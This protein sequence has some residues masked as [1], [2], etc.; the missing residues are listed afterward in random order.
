M[1]YWYPWNCDFVKSV[2]N[3][4]ETIVEMT[5]KYVITG[6]Q[7]MQNEETH[8]L[9]KCIIP[10]NDWVMLVLQKSEYKTSDYI[11]VIDS[12]RYFLGEIRVLVLWKDH[13][14]ISDNPSLLKVF[15][16]NKTPGDKIAN[17]NI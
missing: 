5:S 2:K 16:W 15:Y 8:C 17:V 3:V 7:N 4:D 1:K 13:R 9:T 11:N 10:E 14:A 6:P 12:L